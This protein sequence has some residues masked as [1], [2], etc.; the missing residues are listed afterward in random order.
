VVTLGGFELF[1][2]SVSE[3][4]NSLF[5]RSVLFVMFN[6]F[7]KIF[8]EDQLSDELLFTGVVLSEIIDVILK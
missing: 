2:S 4:V 7:S 6:N 8:L 5:I 1:G 3:L